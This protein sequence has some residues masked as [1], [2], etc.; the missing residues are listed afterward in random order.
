M[1]TTTN[2]SAEEAKAVG[3]QLGIKWDKFDVDQFR[4]GMDVELEHGT[5]DPATNVTNDDPIMTGKIAL[6]HLNE[7][8]DYYDRLEEM[9]EEAEEFWEKN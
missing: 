9:E 8:P 3:E 7:F 4:R 5:I 6:A 1:L 2:F